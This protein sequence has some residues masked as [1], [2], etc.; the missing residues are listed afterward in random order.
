MGGL[1]NP[2]VNEDTRSIIAQLGA[3]FAQER[4]KSSALAHD[5]D[6]LQSSE[7]L[8][9]KA[10]G[11]LLGLEMMPEPRDFL[12]G[13]RFAPPHSFASSGPPPPDDEIEASFAEY[14]ARVLRGATDQRKS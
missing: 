11:I 4:E 3:A 13:G 8:T 9:R 10:F 6:A 5:L 14:R 7:F 2:H 1:V 12:E